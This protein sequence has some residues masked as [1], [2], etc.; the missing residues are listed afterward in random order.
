MKLRMKSFKLDR[1]C[2]YSFL[3][4]LDGWNSTSDLLKKLCGEEFESS[5][6]SSGRYLRVHLD[7]SR[8]SRSSYH[9]PGFDAVHEAVNQRKRQII[10]SK[11]WVFFFVSEKLKSSFFTENSLPATCKTL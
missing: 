4:I 3:Y 11:N 7:S 6:F 8:V 2:S 1:S 10:L 5:V 9:A